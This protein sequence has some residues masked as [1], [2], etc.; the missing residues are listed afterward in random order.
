MNIVTS[1]MAPAVTMA[2]TCAT[3]SPNR[4]PPHRGMM[5]NR[6]ARII[7]PSVCAV[8]AADRS[9]A[10]RRTPLPTRRQRCDARS[11][12]ADRARGLRRIADMA[13]AN[14]PSAAESANVAWSPA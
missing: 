2:P 8:A 6:P 9:R 3:S 12:V 4:S 10:L 7:C 5:R 14:P 1:R 11:A 13:S